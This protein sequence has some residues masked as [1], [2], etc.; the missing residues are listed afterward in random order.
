MEQYR[1]YAIQ[2][3]GDRSL[4]QGRIKTQLQNVNADCTPRV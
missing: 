2:N 3:I 1:D 4:L